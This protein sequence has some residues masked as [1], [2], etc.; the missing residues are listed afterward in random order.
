MLVSNPKAYPCGN[1]ELTTQI[2]ELVEIARVYNQLKKGANETTKSVNRG[3]ARL[4]ILALD[5]DP[6][7]IVLHI[8][9]L[10]E[11][12]NIPYIFINN[13]HLLGK[14]CGVPRS[15][16]ACSILANLN[17]NLNDQIIN[18]QNKIEKFLN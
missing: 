9:L 8:P 17:E 10:C 15:V 7:E 16:I 14:A 2:L 5:S 12:K 18:I 6:L 13:K 1:Y 11:D 4:V 3:I